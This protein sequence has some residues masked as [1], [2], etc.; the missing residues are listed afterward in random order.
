MVND[1]GK[2]M[3]EFELPRKGLETQDVESI[4]EMVSHVVRAC[5]ACPIGVNS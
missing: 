4:L 3:A 5:L 1:E 2:D